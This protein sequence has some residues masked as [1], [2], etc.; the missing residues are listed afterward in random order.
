MRQNVGL[1][2]RTAEDLQG[3]GVDQSAA[4][5]GFGTVAMA[6]GLTQGSGDITN[7]KELI[8]ATLG[9]NAAAQQNVERVVKSRT[10]RFE[11]GGSFYS[12]NKGGSGLGSATR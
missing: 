9:G 10:A 5:G 12:D 2:V 3:L 4:R 8:D 1:D 11:K 6:K 7:N